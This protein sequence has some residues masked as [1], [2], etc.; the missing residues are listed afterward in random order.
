MDVSKIAC[1]CRIDLDGFCLRNDETSVFR[2]P[3][4]DNR[5]RIRQNQDQIEAG[6]DEVEEIIVEDNE[7]LNYVEKGEY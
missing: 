7:I 5:G 1:G 6:N 4:R 2:V 3:G